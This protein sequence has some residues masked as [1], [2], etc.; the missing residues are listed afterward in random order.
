MRD[1]EEQYRQAR[2]RCVIVA[3]GVDMLRR[4]D[5]LSTT[6]AVRQA[7]SDL[8]LS[9]RTVVFCMRVHRGIGR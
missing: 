2:A 6:D 9:P 8:N 7:A 5:R 4:F 3:R 1:I